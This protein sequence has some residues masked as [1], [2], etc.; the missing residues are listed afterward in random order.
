MRKEGDKNKKGKKVKYMTF[1][2][3][4][5]ERSLRKMRDSTKAEIYR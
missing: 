1:G 5:C 2:N 4:L 3:P